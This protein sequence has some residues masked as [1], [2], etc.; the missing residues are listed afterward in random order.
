LMRTR[1]FETATSVAALC[2][3]SNFGNP[4]IVLSGAC[5]SHSDLEAPESERRQSANRMM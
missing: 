3:L 2:V 4:A 5:L 1:L